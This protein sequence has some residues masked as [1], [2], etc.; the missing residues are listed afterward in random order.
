M[1]KSHC[2]NCG[3]YGHIN[4]FCKEP[5]TSIGILCIKFD[6]PNLKDK[7][8][9]ETIFND[10]T[11]NVI[12]NNFINNKLLNKVIEYNSKIKFLMIQRRHSLAFLEFIRGRYSINDYKKLIKLF[13]LMTIEEHDLIKQK[14]FDDI[15]KYVWKSTANN[16]QY[17]EEYK[18]S[19][20]KFETLKYSKDTNLIKLSFYTTNIVSKYKT[21][22]WGFPKG[23]RNYYEKNVECALRE[24]VEESGYDYNDISIIKNM[25]PLKEVF[26]G[27]DDNMYRHIYYIAVLN[28]DKTVTISDNN[29]EVSNIQWHTYQEAVN[30][31]RNYHTE[32]KKVL[33]EL[34]KFIICCVD[35]ELTLKKEDTPINESNNNQ[36]I[37]EISIH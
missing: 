15:W 9:K 6:D 23:R 32:K 3:K 28:N 35:K 8:I 10:V 11:I 26:K 5:I 4:K 37:K 14:E 7:F 30:L 19:K 13:E 16:K 22:E 21:Q 36:L 31:I 20:I 34:L 29:N 24:F 17:E 18:N 12:K 2:N 25:I 33:N 1:N 27:T